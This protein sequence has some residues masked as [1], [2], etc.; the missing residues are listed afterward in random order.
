MTAHD[1]RD[2]LARTDTVRV[3]TP[4]EAQIQAFARLSVHQSEDTPI[5]VAHTSD[6]DRIFVCFGTASLSCV[7]TDLRVGECVLIPGSTT[8]CPYVVSGEFV[9][10]EIDKVM[11]NQPE[12]G[13]ALGSDCELRGRSA[14]FTALADAA[15][16]HS[17]KDLRQFHNYAHSF[18]VLGLAE[19]QAL[20]AR[21]AHEPELPKW[22]LRA[23]DAYVEENLDRSIKINDLAALC[24]YSTAHFSRLFKARTGRTPHKYVLERRVDIACSQLRES[25][26][27]ISDVAYG[28]GFSSQSHMTSTFKQLIGMTPNEVRCA[29]ETRMSQLVAA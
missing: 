25:E 20:S 26:D 9:M 11:R 19:L 22:Q 29:E 21:A 6:T 12:M 15:R 14:C 27:T 23:I 8:Q 3:S 7:S 10:V 4:N 28:T 13:E 24:D 18:A 17:N 1:T 2:L 5:S 16:R